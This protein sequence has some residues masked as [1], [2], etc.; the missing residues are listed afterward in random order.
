MQKL[1]ERVLT[2][3][4]G[5]STMHLSHVNP[6]KQPGRSS[7]QRVHH[8][9]NRSP[10]RGF[11][12]VAAQATI[13]FPRYRIQSRPVHRLWD[14]VV[15]VEYITLRFEPLVPSLYGEP[16]SSGEQPHPQCGRYTLGAATPFSSL[17]L[18]TD[19]VAGNDYIITLVSEGRWFES[20]PPATPV[21]S[22]VGR[23]KLFVVSAIH[24]R[25]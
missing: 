17:S 24:S 1:A 22:S 25:Q 16:C 8:L 13:A 11:R 2:S 21:G 15:G 12:G 3:I 6:Y 10:P 7:R 5:V 19:V 20:S 18:F 9:C 14:V 4:A 23:V